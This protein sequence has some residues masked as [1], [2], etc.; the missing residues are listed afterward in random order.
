[1][2][3]VDISQIIGISAI[4]D[5]INE[6][7][8]NSGLISGGVEWSGTGLIYD[9]TSC[10]FRIQRVSYTSEPSQ[11]TLDASDPDDDRIDVIYADIEGTIA[12]VTGTPSGSPT[13][14]ALPDPVNN[15]EIA[16]ILVT[17]ASTQPTGITYEDI[18]LENA[19]SGSGEW[20]ASTSDPYTILASNEDP[21]EGSVHVLHTLTKEGNN[22][23]VT[24][25]PASKYSIPVAGTLTM[26]MKLLYPAVSSYT[27]VFVC[28]GNEGTLVGSSITLGGSSL[29]KYGLDPNNTSNYQLVSVPLSEF[30]SLPEEVDELRFYNGEFG[31]TGFSLDK[32]RIQEGT[33]PELITSLYL[34]LA[35]GTMSGDIDLGNNVVIKAVNGGCELNLRA[36]DQDHNILITT[37]NGVENESGIWMDP[38]FVTIFGQGW[39]QQLGFYPGQMVLRNNT[40]GAVNR[41]IKLGVGQFSSTYAIHIADNSDG[42]ITAD[43]YYPGESR[44]ATIIGTNGGKILQN[45]QNSVVLGGTGVIARSNNS[46]YVQNLGFSESLTIEGLLTKST[47]TADRAWT[48]PDATGT[49]ALTSDFGAYLP[50]AGGTMSGDITM[51][52]STSITS[53]NGGAF[54]H[55]DD[56]GFANSV[57]LA[58]NPGAT[59]A[60]LYLDDT[61]AEL[62]AASTSLTIDATGAYPFLQ[63]RVAAGK[64]FIGGDPE[65]AAEGNIV[66]KDNAGDTSSTD[67]TS[68]N[69]LF[70]NARNATFLPGV[71]DSVIIGGNN[72][73]AKTN[74]TAY[75]NQLS[76]QPASNIFDG[77][78]VPPSL[79]AD[80]QWDLPDESGTISLTSDLGAYLPLAGGTMSGDIYT[81]SNIMAENGASTLNL[82]DG[83]VNNTISLVT[84]GASYMQ[85]WLFLD[86]TLIEMSQEGEAG[87]LLLHTNNFGL[88]SQEGSYSI[89]MYGPGGAGVQ[90]VNNTSS[91]RTTFD[92]NSRGIGVGSKNTQFNSGV[93]D[94]VAI[95]GNNI[96]V[97]TANTAY[98]NQLSLQPASNTFDGLLVPPA[99]SADRQWDLP[100]ES[101]T[102]AL[103]SAIDN[104]SY[105][106]SV[107]ITNQS[108]GVVTQYTDIETA[109]AAAVSGDLVHVYPGSYTIATTATNGIAKQGVNFFFEPGANVLKTSAGDMF[110]DTGFTVAS[111]VYGYGNFTKT[112]SAGTIFN[113]GENID[114]TIEYNNLLN[115]ATGLCIDNTR[116]GSLP[117]NNV[118]VKGKSAISSAGI[119]MIF[120]VYNTLDL[121]GGDL[122]KSTSGYALQ[123]SS[124]GPWQNTLRGTI[125]CVNINTTAA[126]YSVHVSNY[127]VFTFNVATSNYVYFVDVET[128]TWIGNIDR[129]YATNLSHTGNVTRFDGGLGNVSLDKC[130]FVTG[131]GS[132]INTINYLYGSTSLYN[133]SFGGTATY[134]I[135]NVKDGTP[136]W[137]SMPN[138]ATV[139]FKSRVSSTGYS[140]V[141]CNLSGGKLV[142]EKGFSFTGGDQAAIYQSGGTL[143]LEG[144]CKNTVNGS[145]GSVVNK[146]GGTLVLRNPTLI[147]SNAFAETIVCPA[148]AQNIHIQ[149]TL[150][151]NRTEG[152]GLLVAKKQKTKYT[153][154]SVAATGIKLNDGS[155]GDETFNESDTATY[156]TAALLAQRIAS[157]VNGSGTL[158]CTATQDIPGTDNYFYIESDFAGI[159]FTYIAQPNN[160]S[161]PGTFI[162]LNNYTIDNI[163]GG[164]IIEDADAQ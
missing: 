6:L 49:I 84:D 133:N 77:L 109:V 55:L 75:T 45:V 57:F 46:A 23:H 8:P 80:R 31:I 62:I 68:Y 138:T 105:G 16:F 110:N 161:N 153:V 24:F 128:V 40:S 95:G 147:T 11:I 157:L 146:T 85:S 34:P 29:I 154:G 25:S 158:D 64:M 160:L 126:T 33:S 35:G 32:I 123:L 38:D 12:V 78:L 90:L 60:S 63:L 26:W 163:V 124:I 115:S 47:L 114:F 136:N 125:K 51:S 5:Q 41:V 159:P 121:D 59:G 141:T 139:I 2:G 111:N 36:Y 131:A 140:G 145:S 89:V 148:S 104:I 21:Y 162:R 22:T 113:Y 13:K 87:R 94:S 69:S 155:G 10:S 76:L 70:L 92:I 44:Q 152:G 143:E 120:R 61:Y 19:G 18:Y 101:G 50:L 39:N 3:L 30:G 150:L 88:D 37:D 130:A 43:T 83:G 4:Q 118:K 107:E 14:P 98:A 72:V 149:S 20:D 9:V 66:I 93:Y 1:M 151:S 100:D 102:I 132:G 27:R 71:K 117:T 129:L 42:D 119:C 53:D 48:L 86:P 116:S 28:F 79:S 106:A 127:G 15:V 164:T 144:T 135:H 137:I 74:N 17:A 108:T 65:E 67:N 82:R 134:I 81:D 99:L 142:F 91:N 52:T 112:T 103:T 73:T 156:N 54:L 96:T 122:I 56:G 7:S 58:S 97:K